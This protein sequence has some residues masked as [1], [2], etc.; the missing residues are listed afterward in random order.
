GSR[1][2]TGLG[3]D[4]RQRLEE[5]FALFKAKWGAERAAG[6]HLP[7][8]PPPA[9]GTSAPAAG[10]AVGAA[11]APTAVRVGLPGRSRPRLSLC[12]IVRDEEANLPD[13][14]GSVADL[15]DE[16]VVVDTG[17]ADRAQEVAARFG[18]KVVDFP[19]VDSFAAARNESL[20]H[21]TG[22]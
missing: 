14:L 19:W 1:T 12:M 10:A 11:D 20:R 16:V 17:S 22:D 8:P 13:C 9:E 15:V 3:L 7:G 6:Y 21:A 4:C 5:N 2:F 18:A